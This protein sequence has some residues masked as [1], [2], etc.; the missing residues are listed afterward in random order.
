M[1]ISA[2][3]FVLDAVHISMIIG[4]DLLNLLRAQIDF[5]TKQFVHE[6]GVFSDVQWLNTARL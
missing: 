1:T 2:T 6:S 3:F 4:C 5:K